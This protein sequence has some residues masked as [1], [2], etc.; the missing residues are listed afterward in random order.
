MHFTIRQL[1]STSLLAVT[2][3]SMAAPVA[4]QGTWETTLKGRDINGYAV[5]LSD[6]T[7]AFFYDTRLNITWLASMR[8]PGRMNWTRANNWAAGLTYFGGGWRLPTV[9]DSGTSGCNMNTAGG[10]DCGYNV[11]T[12]VGGAYSEF[13]DLFYTTLGNLA[14]NDTTGT[15]R[16]GTIGVDYGLTNTAYFKNMADGGYWTGTGHGAPGSM[17]AWDFS[18]A[19]GWQAF[20]RVTTS[21]NVVAVR[22]GDVLV[23]QQTADNEIPEPGTLALALAAVA[24]LV[25]AQRRRA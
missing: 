6:P 11:Q 17:N 20:G 3:S 19:T 8:Q 15:A 1:L 14:A 5:S 10:T 4:G 7:A 13:A 22:A 23:A 16:P 21:L 12:Q 2:A 18:T 24:G 9:I 25:A